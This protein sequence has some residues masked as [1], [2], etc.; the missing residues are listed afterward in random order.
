MSRITL[1]LRKAGRSAESSVD[2]DV[3]GLLLSRRRSEW[4][5][6]GR[7]S[8]HSASFMSG[9]PLEFMHPASHSFPAG[10]G[11]PFP[12]TQTIPRGLD[13]SADTP[14]THNLLHP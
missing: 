5:G 8:Y 7:V 13:N 12:E 9:L 14:D 2:D 6:P 11:N 3:G 4:L 10:S 1:N